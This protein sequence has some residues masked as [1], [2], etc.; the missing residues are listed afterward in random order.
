MKRYLQHFFI[1]SLFLSTHILSAQVESTTNTTSGKVQSEII[2]D[3][4]TTFN[5]DIPNTEQ[6]N[7]IEDLFK[8]LTD[9][10]LQKN[11]KEKFVKNLLQQIIYFDSQTS[12]QLSLQIFENAFNHFNSDKSNKSVAEKLTK[13][14]FQSLRETNG[15]SLPIKD[16]LLQT[17]LSELGQTESSN[18]SNLNLEQQLAIGIFNHLTQKDDV[19]TGLFVHLLT[20]TFERFITDTSSRK[21]P[22]KLVNGLWKEFQNNN[23]PAIQDLKKNAITGMFVDF[24]QSKPL[25]INDEV[26]PLEQKLIQGIFKNFIKEDKLEDNLYLQLL[27]GTFERFVSDNSDKKVT[28]KLVNGLWKEFQNNDSPAMQDLK[29]NAVLGLVTDFAMDSSSQ[30]IEQ[31]LVQ[32]VFQRFIKKENIEDNV[33]LLLLTGVVEYFI[34]DTTSRKLPQKLISGLFYQFQNSESP[35]VKKMQESAVTGLFTDFATDDSPKSFEQKLIQGVFQR[36]VKEDD[37]ENS[38]GLQLL[39]GV[40]EYFVQDT[41]SRKLPQKLVSGLFYQFKNNDSPAAAS[42]RKN[43]I[44][45]LFT[46]FSQDSTA[47]T[48]EQ[49][50][51]GGIFQRFV[52]KELKEDDLVLQLL[53]GTFEQFIQDTSSVSVPKKLVNGLFTQ[54]RTTD[55][56]SQDFKEGFVNDMIVQFIGDND[57]PQNIEQKL[58]KGALGHFF[59]DTDSEKMPVQLVVGV[60]TN[61][62]DDTT[63]NRLPQKLVNGVFKELQNP[64]SLLSQELQGSMVGGVFHNFITDTT[65]RSFE[66]KLITGM[67][68][69]FAADSST[70]NNHNL[71]LVGGIYSEFASDTTTQ[72]VPRKLLKGTFKTFISDTVG[73]EFQQKMMAGFY[74][75]FLLD[76]SDKSVPKRLLSGVYKQFLEDPYSDNLEQRLMAGMF[77]QFIDDTTGKSF[78]QKLMDGAFLQLARGGFNTDSEELNG[79]VMYGI[80]NH[81]ATDTVSQ[82]LE[83][84]LIKGAFRQLMEQDIGNEFQ[85]KLMNG[86]FEQFVLDKSD[87]S[88]PKKLLTGAFKHFLENPDDNNLN[89]Q[90]MA[91]IFEQF[92]EGEGKTSLEGKLMSGIFEK[93]IDDKLGDDLQKQ[94]LKGVFTEVLSDT[95]SKGIHRKLVNG[96]FSEFKKT[97]DSG[98]TKGKKLVSGL[99]EKF[100]D[101]SDT[102]AVSQRF[103]QKMARGVY[104]QFVL[105]TTNRRVE[106]KL[107]QGLYTQFMGDTTSQTVSQKLITGLFNEFQ[108]IDDDTT[109]GFWNRYV[110]GMFNNFKVGEPFTARGGLNIN[111]RVYGASGIENRQ[112]P[113]YWVLSSNTDINIY[114]LNIPFSALVSIDRTEINLKPPPPPPPEPGEP[115]PEPL[116]PIKEKITKTFA[117]IGASP[118]YKWIT[119]HGGHRNITFSDYTMSH[120]TYLGGGLELNPGKVRL[121]TMVGQLAK[122][123]P[124]D[125]A[126]FE[127]NVP[128][129]ERTGWSSKVGYGTNKNFL[130]FI[131]LK[132]KDKDESIPTLDPQQVFPNENLVLGFNGQATPFKNLNLSVE[133]AESATTT[134]SNDGTTGNGQFPFP[135]FMLEERTSTVYGKMMDADLNYLTKDMNFAVKYQYIDPNYQSLGAYFFNQDIENFLVNT[136]WAAF[137]RKL[138]FT[139][140]FGIQKDNLDASKPSTLTRI[141]GAANANYN[142]GD[143]NF[144]ANY[145]N[146]T[147]DIAFVLDSDLDS[148]NAVVVTQYMTLNSTY[149][150]L[151]AAED[152]HN[153][154]FTGSLQEV[155]DEVLDPNRSAASRMLNLNFTYSYALKNGNTSL[156]SNVNYNENELSLVKANRLGLGIGMSQNVLKNKMNLGLNVN[157]FNA[158]VETDNDLV[159]STVNLQ[160]RSNYRIS[161]THHLVVNCVLLNRLSKNNIGLN[162]KSNE[163]IANVSYQFNFATKKQNQ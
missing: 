135:D 38:V 42:L 4:L 94:M 69:K 60:F 101:T 90:L 109:K 118:N 17:A 7:I 51:I 120:V 22:M 125:V 36:F 59:K 77:Q 49:K 3:L 123:E 63:R 21:V 19:N 112:S 50:L 141:I 2:Q 76:E 91:G 107:A 23:S 100:I 129:Y 32:G 96:V 143:F 126:L 113:L 29:K 70:M 20:G 61:M 146:Y 48:L 155:T 18:D 13:G 41:T 97:D 44:T 93:V 33:G 28:M 139:G 162:Q 147:T 40:V 89:Q 159:N 12:E 54:F 154:I 98:Q 108:K 102:S 124:Q 82:T 79:K 57:A 45:G 99:F 87:K 128:K 115:E 161:P 153:F 15:K 47:R 78:T 72:S 68:D 160:F 34:Q 35:V 105:D 149:S 88:V 74:E 145:S 142:A 134:N 37:I 119:A 85:R 73:N 133:Y 106:Q 103:E 104:E 14:I 130:D 127:P 83:G 111:T 117:R 150:L 64:E 131:V 144:A 1:L 67:F 39:T 95:T 136:S 156:S 27:T 53:A 52:K 71:Q 43:A 80:F 163:F 56:A 24:A 6:K 122:P 25:G 84:K 11:V 81:F 8:Q 75:Q 55:L 110:N 62:V 46:D 16:I 9:N 30:N 151:T 65:E 10:V 140:D 114:K 121:A 132:A 86:V 137:G 26:E 66:Q 58:I 138:Q 5:D 116:P 31:K 157:Y 158:K 152:Q 148:L 92:I